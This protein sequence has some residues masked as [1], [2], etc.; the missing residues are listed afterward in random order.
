M[1]LQLCE[2]LRSSGTKYHF[3]WFVIWRRGNC[4]SWFLSKER[5][6]AASSMRFHD[7]ILVFI[8]GP[9]NEGLHFCSVLPPMTKDPEHVHETIARSFKTGP[10]CMNILASWFSSFVCAFWLHLPSNI[11]QTDDFCWQKVVK[12]LIYRAVPGFEKGIPCSG[13]GFR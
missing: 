3:W 12:I 13:S 4:C 6:R 10:L 8:P 2:I 11:C 9:P 7:R 1:P 5:K